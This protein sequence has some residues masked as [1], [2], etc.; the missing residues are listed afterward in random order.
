ME[1]SAGE[2]S[3]DSLWQDGGTELLAKMRFDWRKHIVL[4]EHN[5]NREKTAKRK[6]MLIWMI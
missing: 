4:A 6:R 3:G 1:E 5:I 2:G